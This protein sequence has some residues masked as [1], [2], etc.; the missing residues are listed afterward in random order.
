MKFYRPLRPIHAITFDLDDTLYDNLPVIMRMEAEVLAW[1]HREHPETMRLTAQDWRQLKYQ[2]KQYHPH[3]DHDVTLW[4]QRQLELGFTQLGYSPQAA[5]SAA[6]HGVEY[7][8]SWRNRVEVPQ[9]THEVLAQLQQ[10]LPLVAITNGNVDIEKIGLSQYFVNTWYA[11]KD[12]AA[13]PHP[14]L[15]QRASQDLAI[16]PSAILHVGDHLVTDVQGAVHNGYQSCWFNGDR[17]SVYQAR[18]ARALPDVEI[19]HLEQL[20]LIL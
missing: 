13:K 14:D 12:G 4:R 5:E 7:A 10:R 3:I 16:A 1:L 8:L 20:L 2:V 17:K 11:G 6:R 19:T 15:F 9:A 18:K